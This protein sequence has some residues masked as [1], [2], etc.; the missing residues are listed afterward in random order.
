MNVPLPIF[1]H[2]YFNINNF[3]SNDDTKYT[4]VDPNVS[5]ELDRRGESTINFLFS[6]QRL[7]YAVKFNNGKEWWGDAI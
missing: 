7:P 3:V 6:S 2:L 4:I 5:N 1:R